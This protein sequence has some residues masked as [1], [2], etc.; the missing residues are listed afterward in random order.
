[1]PPFI[2]F[3]FVEAFPFQQSSS[4]A[5]SLCDELDN[6]TGLLDLALGVLADVSGAND[7]W[8]LGDSALAED[9]AVAEGEEVEDRCSVLGLAGEVLLALLEG[10]EGPKLRV[11]MSKFVRW[12]RLSS[13]L[14]LSRLMT[15]FQ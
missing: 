6:T 12:Q 14:T 5:T 13:S 1:M 11:E 9:F 8:D 3:L 2:T 7:Q 15:G 4:Q 10:N